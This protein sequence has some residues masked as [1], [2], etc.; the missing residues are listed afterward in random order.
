MSLASTWSSCT[1]NR[2]QLL[3]VADSLWWWSR[4]WWPFLCSFCK[5]ETSEK[6]FVKSSSVITSVT[7]PA[8]S[9]FASVCHKRHGGK[10]KKTRTTSLEFLGISRYQ[11]RQ[12]ESGSQVARRRSVQ[13]SYLRSPII[14]FFDQIRL[15][16][17]FLFSF[18]IITG[19]NILTRDWE[20]STGHDIWWIIVARRNR[21]MDLAAIQLLEKRKKKRERTQKRRECLQSKVGPS[22]RMNW[23][24]SA[25]DSLGRVRSFEKKPSLSFTPIDRVCFLRKPPAKVLNVLATELRTHQ[26]WNNTGGAHDELQT[27]KLGIE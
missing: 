27:S 15:R 19:G 1:P 6:R 8:I 22:H 7:R 12:S 18:I 14:F 3:P 23:W 10:K 5:R 16:G 11:T 4:D 26:L 2:S 21:K 25:V 13:P 24:L 17:P 9:L 20:A